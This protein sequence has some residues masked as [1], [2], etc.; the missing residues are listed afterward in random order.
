MQPDNFDEKRIREIDM[1]VSRLKHRHRRSLKLHQDCTGIVD[2]PVCEDGK[3][4][5]GITGYNKH[6][7]G[8]CSTPG[9]ID[10]RE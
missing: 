1:L 2:C 6:S 10:W 3:V 9:C 4:A 7:Q 8:A 5:Y